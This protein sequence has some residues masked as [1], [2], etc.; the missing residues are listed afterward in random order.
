MQR[1]VVSGLG[2]QNAAFSASGW[3]TKAPEGLVLQNDFGFVIVL[4]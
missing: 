2:F 4:Y 3:R 1:C